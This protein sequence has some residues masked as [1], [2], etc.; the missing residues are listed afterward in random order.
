MHPSNNND[1]AQKVISV[2]I[3]EAARITGLSRGSIYNFARRG[4]LPLRKVGSRTLVMVDDLH[5]LVS[6]QAA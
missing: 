5:R 2:G 3:N 1:A 4:E 6:G